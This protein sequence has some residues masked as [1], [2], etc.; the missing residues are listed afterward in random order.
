MPGQEQVL[1]TKEIIVFRPGSKADIDAFYLLWA[2]T[3]KVVRDQWK[4]VIFMQTNRE[5]V[6][7]RYLEIEIPIA[8][9]PEI[10]RTVSQ[11]FREYF[12]TIASARSNL[13]QYLANSESP[14]HFFVAG[15]DDKGGG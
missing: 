4:R 11:P 8:P 1:T 12:E 2:M 13:Q 3:L 5:D 14:H 6:G 9:T 15:G 7:K 10:A